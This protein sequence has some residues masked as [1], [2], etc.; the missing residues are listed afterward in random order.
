MRSSKK[1]LR[2]TKRL[3][4][5]K[6]YRSPI[7]KKH[8]NKRKW[9]TVHKSFDPLHKDFYPKKL[10]NAEDTKHWKV[11]PKDSCEVY[12][13]RRKRQQTGMST[14]PSE[15]IEENQIIDRDDY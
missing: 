2:Y 9:Y 15:N 5:K 4:R 7:C 10:E 13:A 14:R 1:E 8:K 3:K 12:R 11:M 6:L